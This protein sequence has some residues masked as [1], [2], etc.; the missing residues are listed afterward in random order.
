MEKGRHD[1]EIQNSPGGSRGLSEKK[2][3]TSTVKF[4]CFETIATA[5][6]QKVRIQTISV[7][8]P[9]WYPVEACRH[10]QEMVISLFLMGDY[11]EVV[12]D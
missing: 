6:P 2:T 3:L 8:L 12:V 10:P 9:I 5:P 4:S 7:T 11:Q 1:S